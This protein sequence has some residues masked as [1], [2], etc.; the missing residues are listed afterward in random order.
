MFVLCLC[1]CVLVHAHRVIL[2]ASEALKTLFHVAASADSAT[3]VHI[4]FTSKMLLTF[5]DTPFACR[6]IAIDVATFR[7]RVSWLELRALLGARQGLAEA[8]GVG[9]DAER[10][11]RRELLPLHGEGRRRGR[12]CSRRRAVVASLS[13]AQGQGSKKQSQEQRT[14]P[15]SVHG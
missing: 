7:L 3:V 2:D 12:R 10:R 8:F 4:I 15:L 1:C 11:L 6:V 5:A 13:I 14:S 9:V